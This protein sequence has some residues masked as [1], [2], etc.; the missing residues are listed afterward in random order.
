MRVGTEELGAP[1]IGGEEECLPGTEIEEG[2]TKRSNELIDRTKDT[3]L[4]VAEWSALKRCARPC[5]KEEW[6]S[7]RNTRKRKTL[8]NLGLLQQEEKK[9]EE[10]PVEEKSTESDGQVRP[11]PQSAKPPPPAKPHSAYSNDRPRL[12]SISEAVEKGTIEGKR[13]EQGKVKGK[14]ETAAGEKGGR[15][16]TEARDEGTHSEYT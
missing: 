1:Q 5:S 12:G 15:C 16:D 14:S 4:T 9:A 2:I 7:M 8:E 6:R 13:N 11:A 3:K 10:A